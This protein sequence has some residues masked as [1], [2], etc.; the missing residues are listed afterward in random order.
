MVQDNLYLLCAF[1]LQGMYPPAMPDIYG[2]RHPLP[3]QGHRYMNVGQAH[4][5]RME[6]PSGPIFPSKNKRS[7]KYFSCIAIIVLNILKRATLARLFIINCNIHKS[8]SQG[9]YSKICIKQPVES[10]D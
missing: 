3:Q 9:T 4:M 6:T 2:N 10:Y 5:R 1:F 7:C 8:I